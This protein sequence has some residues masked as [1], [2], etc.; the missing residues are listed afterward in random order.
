MCDWDLASHKPTPQN[1]QNVA[2]VPKCLEEE[3]P[4]IQART[5]QGKLQIGWLGQRGSRLG[6]LQSD[7]TNGRPRGPWCMAR[8]R[9]FSAAIEWQGKAKQLHV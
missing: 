2:A 7:T 6:D 8:V 4:T 5:R 9:V 1:R 3:Y